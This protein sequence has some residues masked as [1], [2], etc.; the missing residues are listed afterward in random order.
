MRVAV[1]H[2]HVANA[3]GATRRTVHRTRAMGH[4]CRTQ[5]AART[6]NHGAPCACL[7][8][9]RVIPGIGR[10]HP[11]TGSSMRPVCRQLLR[12]VPCHAQAMPHALLAE[13]SARGA[14]C[15][16]RAHTRH[17]CRVLAGLPHAKGRWQLPTHTLD[18][19]ASHTYLYMHGCNNADTPAGMRARTRTLICLQIK[20]CAHR[21]Y[22]SS[23][24]QVRRTF[25]LYASAQCV[26]RAPHRH[27][28]LVNW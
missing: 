7:C 20:V 24:M 12:C 16:V 9:S 5:C 1:R 28:M 17:V 6:A 14:L 13:W 11:A 18:A 21:T 26:W 2:W 8:T 4:R 27:E 10:S 23:L 3:L 19:A 22:E 25:A 15:A